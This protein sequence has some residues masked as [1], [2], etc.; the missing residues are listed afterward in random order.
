M[1]F[2]VGEKVKIIQKAEQKMQIILLTENIAV[3]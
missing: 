3:V 2:M 1:A